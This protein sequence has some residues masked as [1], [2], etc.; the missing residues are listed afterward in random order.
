MVGRGRIDEPGSFADVRFAKKLC[1]GNSGETSRES[2]EAASRA[3]REGN[4]AF[5]VFFL[6]V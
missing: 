2:K 6:Q 4:G 1:V 3:P 5:E